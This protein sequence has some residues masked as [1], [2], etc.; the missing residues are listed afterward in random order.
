MK[1][2]ARLVLLSGLITAAA[3][4]AFAQATQQ[5]ELRVTVIDQTGASIPMARVRITPAAGASVEAVVSERGQTTLGAL[6]V[7][8]VQLHVEAD[9]FSPV[10]RMLTLRRGS[11]NQTITLS[12]A[13]LQEEIVVSDATA[14]DTRGNSLTTTLEEDEIAELSDDPDELRAQLEAMTGG[15]G[16]V[17]Q[18]NG[19]RGGRLPNRDEIRQI[20]FRT[21]SFSAD[22]HDAGRV[23]VEIITRPGLTEWSGNANFGL[24]ND[25][26]NARNSFARTQTPEQFRRFTFGLRGPLV[27]NRTS[28]RFNVDGNRSF[29]SGTIVALLPD[30]RIGDQVKR[31]FEQTNFMAGLE[32]GFTTNQTFRFEYRRSEDA[33]H[34]LGVGDFNL[35]ERAYDRSSNSDQVRASAQSI[36]GRSALNEFRVEFNHQDSLSAS[37]SDAPAVI[38]IDAFSRGGAGVSSEGSDRTLEVANNLDFNVGKHAMRAGFL[39]ESGAYINHDAR[40]AAGT[41]T[42]SSLEAFL[43]GTPNTFTQRLGEVRTA[44]SQNQLGVYWQDD[45]RLNRRLA[46]SVGVREELQSHVGD[47]M[48]FMPRLGVTYT[49]QRARTT[50][51]GGYGVFH[52]WYESSLYDQTLRVTGAAGAQR[53]LLVLNPGYP[54]PAGGVE[55]TVLGGGR[56]QADPDLK[57]PHVHQASI[58]V[59]RALTQGIN[60]QASYMLMRGR[61]QLRSRNVNAPD[62]FG[63]RPEPDVGTVAQIEST[64]RSSTD[65]I[66][67]NLNYRVPGRR[68]FMNVGYTW[69]NVKSHADNALSLPADSLNPDAEWGPSSQ[70]VRHR[71]NAMVNVG[72]PWAIRAN[73]SGTAQSASPYTITTGRDDNR[74]GVSNDRPAGV[75]RN[76]ERGAARFDMNVRFSRGFGFGG[77]GDENRQAGSGGG[78]QT[79]IVA[80]SPDGGGQGPG[81]GGPIAVGGPGGGNTNQRFTLAFYV[82]GF[83][84]LNRTNFVNFSG[85]L[86]SPFFGLPT[87]AAQ[88]RRV[89]VGMQFRF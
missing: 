33:R 63:L 1:Q 59:E 62:A 28:L 32:H 29:D 64:G 21:N 4:P 23:Q 68:T 89:E 53:D 47:A 40:N 42:F 7:G 38:V 12:I 71:L 39:L 25:V 51:R 87:S 77:S 41:F 85:N 19:F 22:N 65:R 6:P 56:V 44:F 48:N 26:L 73:I 11:T 2:L 78:G 37:M 15:A 35:M 54:D 20:R 83:N 52:D 9:G 46:V 17:F 36:L 24:R 55:A 74:D 82:Q 16:A 70:D 88:A 43:A 72:L 76:S 66:H 8:N 13:G 81:G 79:L 61:N 80:P 75:G 10:D 45:Y 5:A 31:P 18:V 86:L 50:I 3:S 84:V 49:P 27:Q 14:D 58:G 69:S 30:G 67:V 57:M 34:N 60:F